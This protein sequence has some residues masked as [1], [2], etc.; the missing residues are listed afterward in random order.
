MWYYDY[1]LLPLKIEY[2]V[3]N[4]R[5]EFIGVLYVT[6]ISIEHVGPN[7]VSFYYIQKVKDSWR[8]VNHR[9]IIPTVPRLM[10]YCHVAEPVYLAVHGLKE[11][12][13]SGISILI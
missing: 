7:S 11:A 9:D 6:F 4:Q 3:L 10:G 12:L 5:G 8:V 1:N 2:I 13:V